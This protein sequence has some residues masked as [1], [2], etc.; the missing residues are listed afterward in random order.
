MAIFAHP[1]DAETAAGGLLARYADKN[2]TVVLLTITQGDKG[3]GDVDQ[4]GEE[5]QHAAKTLGIKHVVSLGYKDSEFDNDQQLRSKLTEEIRTYKPQV[6]ICP[7]PTAV[8]FSDVYVNHQDHRRTGY[9][10]IDVVSSTVA[11]PKFG[12]TDAHVVEHLLCAGTQEPNCVIDISQYLQA[13]TDAVT[14][15]V[16]QI[17]DDQESV[18]RS[19]AST[20]QWVGSQVGIDNGE[21]YRH[22]LLARTV[23]QPQA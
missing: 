11:N 5:S 22:C 12:S 9:A 23:G 13:K 14:S 1:D 21:A 7:D 20:S 2:T 19:L 4:R 16:S 8:F 6:V 17:G 10:V 3:R 15:Y 18:A